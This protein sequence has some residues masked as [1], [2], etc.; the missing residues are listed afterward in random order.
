MAH[1]DLRNAFLANK[2]H[3]G[4]CGCPVCT[5]WVDDLNAVIEEGRGDLIA[6]EEAYKNIPKVRLK[7]FRHCCSEVIRKEADIPV[8]VQWAPSLACPEC[9]RVEIPQVE[10]KGVRA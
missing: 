4:S 3:G 10:V 9:K 6:Y 2:P 7:A 1:G 8:G 5:K